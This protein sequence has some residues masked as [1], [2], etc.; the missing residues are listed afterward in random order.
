[1]VLRIIVSM[2]EQ[3]RRTKALEEEPVQVPFLGFLIVLG[4]DLF[5]AGSNV[6][7]IEHLGPRG[8]ADNRVDSE[9]VI[10]VL[11][12]LDFRAKLLVIEIGQIERSV[13]LI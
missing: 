9:P 13:E 5:L 10:E 6:F 7:K 12:V 4:S 1:M 11:P 8:R 2:A 3:M